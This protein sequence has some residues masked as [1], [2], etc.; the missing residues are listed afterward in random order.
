MIPTFEDAILPGGHRPVTITIR[1]NRKYR[2][3]WGP[4]GSNG[5]KILLFIAFR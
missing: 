5:S 2:L 4:S 3:E 1:L